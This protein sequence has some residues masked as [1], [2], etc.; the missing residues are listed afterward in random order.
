MADWNFGLLVAPAFVDPQ[1]GG[2]NPQRTIEEYLN[3]AKETLTNHS[4]LKR[5]WEAQ[6]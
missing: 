2:P 3:K 4:E 5:M 1:S 6:G